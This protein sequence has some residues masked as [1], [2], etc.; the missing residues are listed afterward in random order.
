MTDSTARRV[1]NELRFLKLY[2][3]LS[4]L[5]IATLMV[6]AFRGPR[7]ETFDVIDVKRINV[8]NESG[9]PALAIAGLGRLP[10]PTFEGKEY[11][12]E[13]SGGRTGASG[14]IFFN[15]RGDEV[16]GLTWAGKLVG[17]G[18]QAGGGLMFDQFHQDQVVGLQYQDDGTNRSAGLNVWDRSTEVSIAHILELVDARRTATGAARDSVERA[19]QELAASG[20]GAHRAFLGSRNRA[21]F[22]GLQDPQGRTRVRLSVDSLG[23]ARLE[24]LDES[25]NVTREVSE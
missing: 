25:G 6:A 10:G 2:A 11:P 22:L 20:L 13:L 15:E 8:L 23:V 7:R 19:I 21:A 18:Y 9:T 24:F 1:R 16:G 5:T 14:M 17:D 3:L 4:S 12:Q